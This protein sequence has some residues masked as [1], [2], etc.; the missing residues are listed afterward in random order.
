MR[1]HGLGFFLA[2]TTSLASVLTSPKPIKQCDLHL[3]ITGSS[4]LEKQDAAAKDFAHI[5]LVEKDPKKAWDKYVPGYALPFSL[6]A[7]LL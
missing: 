3:K 6:P 2:A 4:L 7:L 5:F 1:F